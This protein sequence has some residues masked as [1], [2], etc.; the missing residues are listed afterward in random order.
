MSEWLVQLIKE[1]EDY[2]RL[3]YFSR[4]QILIIYFYL[5]FSSEIREGIN[6]VT[7]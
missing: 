6:G 2:N 1:D 4:A 3:G 7:V 5:D